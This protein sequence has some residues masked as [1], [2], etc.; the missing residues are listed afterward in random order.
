M[1]PPFLHDFVATGLSP[2]VMSP[3][4]SNRPIEPYRWSPPYRPRRPGKPQTRPRLLGKNHSQV[5]AVLE[6][7][8]LSAFSNPRQSVFLQWFPWKM[9]LILESPA[10]GHPAHDMFRF[11]PPNQCRLERLFQ[12]LAVGVESHRPLGG[13]PSHPAK[14]LGLVAHVQAILPC[15]A[16][17][18]GPERLATPFCCTKH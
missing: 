13:N 14:G 9:V 6:L 2:Q 10:N 3:E 11:V 1:L 8:F 16:C 4:T 12:F 15:M 5:D 17:S 7:F 18:Q